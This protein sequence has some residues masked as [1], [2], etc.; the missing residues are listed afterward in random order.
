M[1]KFLGTGLFPNRSFT[2]PGDDLTISALGNTMQG[3]QEE[4]HHFPDSS[5]GPAFKE[6]LPVLPYKEGGVSTPHTH[7]GVSGLQS[8][9]SQ[10]SARGRR[11]NHSKIKFSI[12]MNTT[13]TDFTEFMKSIKAF[14]SDE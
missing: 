2:P 9:T 14:E 12:D 13:A 1:E 11:F 7:T 6:R 8:Q 3:L 10:P 5:P 4:E